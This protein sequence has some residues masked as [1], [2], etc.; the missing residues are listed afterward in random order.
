MQALSQLSY[1][2]IR[3][4]AY[5]RPPAWITELRPRPQAKSQT[6]VVVVARHVGD[7]VE[8]NIIIIVVIIED[9]VAEIDVCI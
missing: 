8:R 6:S 3:V 2:P 4:R 9:I 7:V 1:G 5:R